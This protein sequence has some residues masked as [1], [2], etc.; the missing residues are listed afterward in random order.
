MLKEAGVAEHLWVRLA[1]CGVYN[2]GGM[3]RRFRVLAV[4][5]ACHG[6]SGVCH[7]HVR[8]HCA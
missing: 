1:R 2:T 7:A 3:G 4:A 6:D 8:W 5:V